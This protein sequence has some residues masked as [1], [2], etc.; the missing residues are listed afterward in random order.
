M[1]PR[2]MISSIRNLPASKSPGLGRPASSSSVGLAGDAGPHG[3]S[4]RQDARPRRRALRRRPADRDDAARCVRFA[5]S[6]RPSRRASPPGLRDRARRRRLERRR[7][8]GG[9]PRADRRSDGGRGFGRKSRPSTSARHSRSSP[10]TGDRAGSTSRRSG[11][12]RVATTSSWNGVSSNRSS[13]KSRSTLDERRACASFSSRPRSTAHATNR[14]P[15]RSAHGGSSASS[16]PS[17]RAG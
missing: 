12:R 7:R 15:K 8:G 4:G 5:P 6:R 11:S 16:P 3:A 14:G 9:R 13:A 2:P 17:L 10:S 1:P